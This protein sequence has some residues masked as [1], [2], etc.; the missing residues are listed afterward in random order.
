ML[1]FISVAAGLVA[2]TRAGRG[3]MRWS[4]NSFLGG[5]PQYRL[6]KSM[7]EGLAQIESADDVK[8][9]LVSIEEGWQIGYLLESLENGWVAVFLPQAPLAITMVEAMSIVKRIGVG[10]AKVLRGIDLSLPK[11]V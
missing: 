9:A 2:R 1:V 4:E 8:P 7:A 10:S 3:I 11:G 5:L 6:V